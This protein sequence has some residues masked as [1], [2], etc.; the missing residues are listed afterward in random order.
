MKEMVFETKEGSKIIG[1]QVKPPKEILQ[2]LSPIMDFSDG[3]WIHRTRV[4]KYVFLDNS[5]I[6]RVRPVTVFD[7]EYDPSFGL[8]EED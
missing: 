3:I 5:S 7:T 2:S 8:G 6:I 1:I 4:N